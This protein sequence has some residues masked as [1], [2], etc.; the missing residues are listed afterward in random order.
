MNSIKIFILLIIFGGALNSKEI[1]EV[2]VPLVESIMKDKNI[3]TLQIAIFRP[4]KTLFRQFE[5]SVKETK[6]KITKDLYNY[7]IG[8]LSYPI[9]SY[10]YIKELYNSKGMIQKNDVFEMLEKNL[11]KSNFNI[12]IYNTKRKDLTIIP[13]NN[14]TILIIESLFNM[15][16]GIDVSKEGVVLSN[17]NIVENFSIRSYPFEQFYLTTNNFLVLYNV[18]NHPHKEE[19][20]NEFLKKHKLTSFFYKGKLSSEFFKNHKIPM[21]SFSGK[22]IKSIPELLIVN[23][24]SYGMISNLKD[25]VEIINILYK[26]NL[27]FDSF[28]VKQFPT[29]GY[30]NG[31]FYRKTCDNQYYVAENFGFFP[32][33]NSYFF[34]LENGYGFGIFQSSDDEF[35]IHYIRDKIEEI[36]YEIIGINCPNPNPNPM[37]MDYLTGYYRGENILEDSKIKKIFTDIW[38]RFD[39][40]NQLEVSNFFNKDPL[41]SIQLFHDKIFFKGYTKINRYPLNYLQEN[42]QKKI[43]MGIYEYKKIDWFYS[44]RGFIIILV[45]AM[46]FAMILFLSSILWKQV[47]K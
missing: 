1:F 47:K 24:F 45:I 41:G 22:K 28:Y 14:A 46:L 16:S 12:K 39:Y 23:P 29:S 42:H 35:S 19:R 6:V 31:F 38:I 9:I 10:W 4:E 44:I 43:V 26:E 15:A 7:F 18:I 37:D 25:Y 36:L 2:V 3:P 27:I 17:H 13:S 11:S 32:G 34:I 20:L 5:Y 21:G 8:E 40:Q 30:K 33:Y